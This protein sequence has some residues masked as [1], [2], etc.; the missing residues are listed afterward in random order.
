LLANLVDLDE[1]SLPDPVTSTPQNAAPRGRCSAFPP[2]LRH[3]TQLF[4]MEVILFNYIVNIE[5]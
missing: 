2:K 3:C 1:I 4:K 5:S